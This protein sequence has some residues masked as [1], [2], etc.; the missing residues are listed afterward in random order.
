[1]HYGGR[2]MPQHKTYRATGWTLASAGLLASM[3]WLGGAQPAQALPAFSHQTGDACTACHIGSFGPQLTP[4]GREFKLNGYSNGKP[5]LASYPPV[6]TMVETSFSSTGKNVPEAAP[7]FST[8]DNLAVDEVG[9]FLAG[10]IYDHLGIFAQVTWNGIEHKWEWDNSDLRYGRDFQIAGVDTILGV[11]IN[12]NPTISDPYNT[13]PGWGYPYQSAGLAP[14]PAASTLLEGGLGQRVIGATAYGLINDMFYVEAGGYG[15]LSNKTLTD[16]NN[17]GLT[18]SGGAPYVR[19]AFQQNDLKQNYSVGGFMMYAD[20]VP[21]GGAGMGTDRFLDYGFDASYQ[22]LGDRQH[23]FTVNASAI[24]E[25]RKMSASYAMGGVEKENGS[26]QTYKLT[27][28]YWFDQTYGVTLGGFMTRGSSDNVLYAPGAMDGSANGK[29]N[30]TGYIAQLDWVPF[31]K[32]ESFMQPWVNMHMA[33]QY[34]G[35]T[36]FNGGSGNYDGSGRKASDN[37]TVALLTWWAF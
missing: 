16:L 9:L 18:L 17:G 13:L 21:D 20:T 5:G 24:F 12:N 31:G 11:S 14:A 35:Y 33:L 32:K 27:G 36:E 37:N 8:N 10:Q 19:A 34:T 25:D 4:H 26:L 29:P 15:G 30:T 28:S 23:I 1:M 22:W 7:G 2:M 6:S 3:A